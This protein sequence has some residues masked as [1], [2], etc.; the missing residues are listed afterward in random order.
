[1]NYGGFLK[2]RR[3]LRKESL[4]EVAD[5]AGTDPGNLSRLERNMQNVAAYRLIG[6]CRALEMSASELFHELEGNSINPF[7]SDPYS[8]FDP[9]TRKLIRTFNEMTRQ[10]QEVLM[11]IA[12][13]FVLAAKETTDQS[14]EDDEGGQDEPGQPEPPAA[15]HR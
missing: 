8:A 1:M 5:R 15:G 6:V 2:A 12:H 10:Q 11:G 9:E 13:E 7:L 4:Q 3:L 14:G